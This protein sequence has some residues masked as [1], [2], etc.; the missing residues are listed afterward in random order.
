MKEIYYL[1]RSRLFPDDSL[2]SI[3]WKH[4]RK[5]FP[6]IYRY[7]K[8]FLIRN[9]EKVFKGQRKSFLLGIL[10]PI[11]FSFIAFIPLKETFLD[12]I[13]V[14]KTDP[15]SSIETVRNN[16][17][18]S[19][20]I[21]G[22]S[23][24]ALGFIFEIVRDKNHQTFRELSSA[25]GLFP[26]L[27]FSFG[28]VLYHIIAIPLI[29]SFV[30]H[31]MYS[32]GICNIAVISWYLLFFMLCFLAWLTF[33]LTKIFSPDAQINYFKKVLL[34][35]AGDTLVTETFISQARRL[36]VSKLSK[37]GKR[38][39]LNNFFRKTQVRTISV[40]SEY[41]IFFDVKMETLTNNLLVN[42]NDIDAFE[43]IK[44]GDPVRSWHTI[45]SL[46]P[47]ANITS[48]NIKR[49]VKSFVII[50]R[51]NSNILY[52]IEREHLFDR[53]H[54]SLAAND[55]KQFHEQLDNFREIYKLSDIAADHD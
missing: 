17:S 52:E 49:I 21:I 40:G 28:V 26:I 44:I 27:G 11:S 31:K 4:L 18:N 12:F 7:R 38:I 46:T 14:F 41:G 48:K 9:F 47:T 55:M 30:D 45:F 8:S 37:L 33:S 50:R 13:C 24:V 15:K 20:T 1:I 36:Y 25:I 3:T 34:R 43:P 16:L 32:E 39:Y 53:F 54:K 51:R 10:V 2:R 19:A 5:E 35:E 22:I 42:E 23:F 29:E 6:E